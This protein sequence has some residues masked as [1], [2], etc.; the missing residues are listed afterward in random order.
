MKRIPIK[1][2]NKTY[3]ALVDDDVRPEVLN[4]KWYLQNGK[5]KW[6][7]A[8]GFVSKLKG[9]ALMHHVVLCKPPKGMVINHKDNN[10]LNNQ[11]KNLEIVT[12][13]ENIRMMVRSNGRRGVSWKKDHKLFR[14]EIRFNNK[15]IFIGYFKT[16][17][18]AK[19]AYDLKA[20][21]LF[22]Y[23]FNS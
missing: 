22:G 2:K 7:Y 20:K 21:E 23:A 17:N 10:G 18:E 16:F 11:K 13:A 4:H 19:K 15:K 8:C 6:K 9:G 14:A 1:Y 3:Y 12:N 5:T